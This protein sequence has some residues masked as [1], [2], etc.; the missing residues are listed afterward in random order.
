MNKFISIKN[1]NYKI[2]KILDTGKSG[3]SYLISN[4]KIKYVL[5]EFRKIEYSYI[6]FEE[7]LSKE[8]SSYKVLKSIEIPIPNLIDYN[9]EEKYLVKEYIEGKIA[10]ELIAENILNENI[11]KQLFQIVK[12]AYAN[13][14]N[15]D[16]YPK[17]FVYNNKRLYYIDYE[18]QPFTKEWNF[19]N[20]GIYYWLNSEGFAKYLK[21]NNP[22]YINY[23][24]TF[25]PI[26]TDEFSKVRSNWLSKF[27][28]EL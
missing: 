19:E 26:V 15:I 6:K 9:E 12:I 22:D 20:W 17:N 11:L 8:L 18:I 24:N 21:E 14:L 10:T 2:I 4:D 5:K 16:Y 28:N 7:L 25:K 1:E 27:G 3:S 23:Q 13:S